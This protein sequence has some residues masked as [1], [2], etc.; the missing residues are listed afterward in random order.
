[1]VAL[2]EGVRLVERT[3]ADADFYCLMGPLFGS[4]EIARELG[5]PIYDDPERLWCLAIEEATGRVVGCGSIAMHG[6][7]AAFKSAWV[8]PA[9]R[10]RG[11]YDALFRQRMDLLDRHNIDQVTATATAMSRNTH[12]R[13][14][15]S[16]VGRRGRYYLMSYLMR[17]DRN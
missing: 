15:F 11:I 10:G 4:R 7:K 12:L 3:R 16:E 2:P 5:M 1:M 9:W 8:A 6:R 17:K 13:Y 14:G